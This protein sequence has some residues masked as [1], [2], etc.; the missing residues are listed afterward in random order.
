MLLAPGHPSSSMPL[1]PPPP[2]PPPASTLLLPGGTETS[3][4]VW[5]RLAHGCHGVGPW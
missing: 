2:P 5:A 1:P 4:A 3:A